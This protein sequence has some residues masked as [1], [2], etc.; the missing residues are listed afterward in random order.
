[1]TADY[2]KQVPA[3]ERTIRLLEVLA[4][5]PD[6]LTAGE[7]IDQLQLSRSSLFALLNTL[8]ARHYIEQ[9]DSRGRYHLGPALWAL[10]PGRRHGL[11]RLIEA[12]QSD[13]ELT[14][15]PETVALVWLDGAE[16][17]VIAQLESRRPVRAVYRLGERRLAGAS[18]AGLILLAGLPPQTVEQIVPQPEADLTARLLRVQKEGLAQG[19][20]D[21]IIEI[22]GPICPDGTHPGAALVLSLPAFRHDPA[23]AGG[24]IKSLRQAAAR[25]S[26]RLGAPVYQPYG[27]AVGEPIGPTRPLT[28]AEIK[29]FLHGPWGARLACIRQDGTPHVVPL[30]YEWDGHWVWVT[31]SPGAYWQAYVKE[32]SRISLTIDEPWPPLRRALIV[33]RAEPVGGDQIPGGLAG[34]RCRLAA[35]YLGQG[36]EARAEF[37]Q[38]E[39]WEAF[40]I[41]PHKITGYQGLGN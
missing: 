20:R 38:T 33:G 34:L 24:L 35:R 36:A 12:F 29:Q 23:T 27:W 2:S 26:Y 3:A 18:A 25:L 10:I 37:Q 7:L 15:L 41:I 4:A 16:T 13:V 22:A 14:M 9:S 11:G 19:S 39:N 8:K 28:T 40:R 30:W 21:E 1:M 5:A 31:A 32:S 17:V 6:G